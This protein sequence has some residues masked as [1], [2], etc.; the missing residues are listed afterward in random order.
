MLITPSTSPASTPVNRSKSGNSVGSGGRAA[1]VADIVYAVEKEVL[2]VTPFCDGLP[3]VG[4]GLPLTE[5]GT[6]SA[7]AVAVEDSRDGVDR[8]GLVKMGCSPAFFVETP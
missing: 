6:A 1:P 5:F 3:T 7:A 8:R 4:I 2:Y